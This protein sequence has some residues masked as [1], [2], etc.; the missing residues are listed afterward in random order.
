MTVYHFFS[1]GSVNA[2]LKGKGDMCVLIQCLYFME[3][4]KIE[5]F[6]LGDCF[7]GYSI[8]TKDTQKV[9]HNWGLF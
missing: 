1:D 6:V 5:M 4:V 8:L 2:H 3:A 9:S 7:T